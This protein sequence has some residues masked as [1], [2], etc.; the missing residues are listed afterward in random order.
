MTGTG[1]HTKS[2]PERSKGDTGKEGQETRGLRTERAVFPLSWLLGGR[3]YRRS[4]ACCPPVPAHLWGSVRVS[5]WPRRLSEIS[6]P[7]FHSPM[8]L[9]N[10]R[11]SAVR[12]SGLYTKGWVLFTC[13]KNQ[14]LPPKA[15]VNAG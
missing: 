5:L 7:P 15:G 11:L 6:R 3:K 2:H 1:T 12:I 13:P 9:D 4:P 8:K 14:G 10:G